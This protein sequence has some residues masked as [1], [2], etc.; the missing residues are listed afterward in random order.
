MSDI[1]RTRRW[2]RFLHRDSGKAL[3]VPI[4]HGLTLGPIAGLGH[5][6]P[7]RR[8]LASG[9]LTGVLMHKGMVER[10]ADACSAGLIVHLNGAVKTGGGADS[11]TLP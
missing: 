3:I 6:E 4:D 8:W 5:L 10:L 2:R 9:E 11:V 7:I 1:G